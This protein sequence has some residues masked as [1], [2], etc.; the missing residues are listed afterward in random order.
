MFKLKIQLFTLGNSRWSRGESCHLHSCQKN[1]LVWVLPAPPPQNE[2]FSVGRT[3]NTLM[4]LFLLRLCCPVGLLLETSPAATSIPP[5]SMWAPSTNT[6]GQAWNIKLLLSQA[7]HSHYTSLCWYRHLV[8][9]HFRFLR[10]SSCQNRS[11][12]TWRPGWQLHWQMTSRVNQ[13]LWVFAKE[14]KI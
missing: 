7:G 9:L 1:D 11:Q 8:A 4:T 6:I 10:I 3:F 2:D 13:V 5:A 14:I 12:T